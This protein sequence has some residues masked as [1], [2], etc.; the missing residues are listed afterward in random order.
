MAIWQ[1]TCRVGSRIVS[2]HVNGCLDPLEP[3]QAPTSPGDRLGM[4]V[5]KVV[6]DLRST[7]PAT[8]FDCVEILGQREHRL[9]LQRRRT[10]IPIHPAVWNELAD[11]HARLVNGPADPDTP[12]YD[13]T[14]HYVG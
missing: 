8:G 4:S 6:G 13:P 11:L 10:G 9:M 2:F 12:L 14:T 1:A 7:V 5:A 3:V